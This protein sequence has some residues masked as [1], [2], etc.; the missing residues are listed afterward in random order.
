MK[1][2]GFTL[3][4]VLIVVIIIGILA[5]IA[6]PQYINTLEKARSAEALTGLGS[7]RSSM[8]RYWYDQMAT[9]GYTQLSGAAW[10]DSL[11]VEVDDATWTYTVTDTGNTTARNYVIRAEKDS[12]LWIEIDE[13][14]NTAKSTKLGG[15]GVVLP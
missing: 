1:E 3:L 4:E 2:R 8:D 13:E 15:D 11:D 10:V 5:S 9:S 12:T 7:L 14:G 6:L